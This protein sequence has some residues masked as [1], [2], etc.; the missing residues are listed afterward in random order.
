MAF[1][2]AKEAFEP[3]NWVIYTLGTARIYISKPEKRV[4]VTKSVVIVVQ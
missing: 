3:G 4:A 1:R 2:A